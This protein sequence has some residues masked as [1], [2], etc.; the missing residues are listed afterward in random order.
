MANTTYGLESDDV[1]IKAGAA[2]SNVLVEMSDVGDISGVVRDTR[3]EP[4]AGAKITITRSGMM[5]VVKGMTDDAGRYTLGAVPEGGVRVNAVAHGYRRPMVRR[6]QVTLD[7]ITV[8][9]FTMKART[10]FGG[11][12]VS[13]SGAPVAGAAVSRD[14]RGAGRSRGAQSRSRND[15]GLFWVDAP[16]KSPAVAWARHAK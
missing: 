12:V 1:F 16:P 4:I 11:R 7:D 8:V 10:G 13:P 15:E 14:G 2:L 9:N 3:G 6:V 5:K